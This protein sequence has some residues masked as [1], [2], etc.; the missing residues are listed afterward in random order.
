[1]LMFAKGFMTVRGFVDTILLSWHDPRERAASFPA[2][3]WYWLPFGLVQV[4]AGYTTTFVAQYTGAGR[5][6]RVGPAVWQGIHFALVAGLLFL[7]L[8]PAA[9]YLIGLG[10]HSDAL[11]DLEVK[12]LRCLAFAGMP[13]LVMGAVNG[14][15]ANARQ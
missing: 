1:P 15:P 11:Q 3:M 7:A 4:A 5:P 6:H 14:M 13:M 12:Y 2:I 8:A 9:P 10:G